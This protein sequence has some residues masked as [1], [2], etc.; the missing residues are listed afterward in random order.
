[1]SSS[2]RLRSPRSARL[3]IVDDNTLGLQ[4]RK[5]VLEELGYTVETSSA[6]EEAL[7]LV[8]VQAYDLVITDYRMPAMN[9]KQFIDEVRKLRP[10]V[11]IILISGFV[12]IIGLD[13]KST[14]ADAVIQ[15]SNNE[16]N[17]LLRAVDRLLNRAQRKGPS[18]EGGATK[19]RRRQ[20]A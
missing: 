11:P 8:A 15:K 9:G 12:E 10:G 19:R 1:M 5:V 7:A 14:G 18:S 13:E 2:A 16:V 20:G 4:A 3:L 17:S 6:P